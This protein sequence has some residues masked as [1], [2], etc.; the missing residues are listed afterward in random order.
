VTG[1]HLGLALAMLAGAAQCGT[2]G[3]PP[4]SHAFPV[5]EYTLPSGLK[6]V[7]EQDDVST[8]AGI[9]VVVDAGFVDDPAGKRGIAHVLEHLVFRVPDEKGESLWYRLITLGAASFNA[10]T[11]I[12]RTTYHAFGP[13]QTLDELAAMVLARLADPMR[14]AKE[15]HIQK[16][17]SITAEEMRKREGAAGNE[18]LM[19][20]LLPG[21]HPVGRAYAEIRRSDPVSLA[22]VRAFAD[23]FYRPERMTVVISGPVPDG[24]DK[25][26][27]AKL[28][29]ALRGQESARQPPVRRA[30]AA[31]EPP[32][33][34]DSALS[35][36]KGKVDVPELWMAWRVPPSLG[37]TAEKVYAVSWV[38]DMVLSSRLDP[39]GTNDVLDVDGFAYTGGL[40]SAVA[41]RFKLRDVGDAVRIRN[42]TTA[43]IEALSDAT[44]VSIKGRLYWSHVYALQAAKL[45]TAL[46]MDTIEG[47]ALARAELAHS[48]SSAL[49]SSV[50]SALEKVT[51]DDI[52]D[53][54]ARYLKPEAARSVLVV[55]QEAGP[56]RRRRSKP[57]DEGR[58]AGP[59]PEPEVPRE[60]QEAR[61]EEPPPPAPD[62]AKLLATTQAPNARAALV[63]KLSN[64]LTVIAMRRPGL[65]FVSTLLGFHSD[66]QPADAPGARY[67]YER[68]LHWELSAGPLELGLLRWKEYYADE[69]FES[70]RMFSA[71]LGKALDFLAEE[72]D[73]LHVYWPNPA[74]DRWLDESAVIEATP[75]GRA[76]RAFRTALFGK[77]PYH[78]TPT[79]AETRQLTERQVQAWFER[80]RRPANGAL[81][82]VGEIDPEGLV[83]DAERA[84]HGW[85]GDPSPPPAAPAPPAQPASALVPANV[86]LA[87]NGARTI[88]TEDPRRRTADVRFGC[89]LPPV[90]APRD[91][92]VNRLLSNMLSAHLSGQLRWKLAVN[93]SR[94]VGAETVR[95]GSSW[96]S[97]QF[98]V[99]ARAVAPALDLLHTWLDEGT[100]SPITPQRFD[101]LRWD[102]ARRS[103]LMNATGAQLAHSLFE[104][105]NMGWEPAVLDDYP[106]DLA[107]V[108][109]NDLNAALDTCRKSA[110]IS[111]LGPDGPP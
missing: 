51:T 17:L 3:T 95:G 62:M 109:V 16:E 93:Y 67:A 66:P 1:R 94:D 52:T 4:T 63:R 91:N 11:G 23:T 98:D 30:M 73:S 106:R 9:V 41:C 77:H 65:P 48:G 89:F 83:R 90:R 76:S 74:F 57:N 60:A 35:L 75:D 88:H 50:L 13:R 55:P 99:D 43:A 100:A 33:A 101:E 86:V 28:P 32:P 26:F 105:W 40:T 38:L 103:G 104:A 78:L 110:V 53:F 7:I 39:D 12:E 59:G 87:K 84:L 46:Q 29:P 44:L 34:G 10:F 5:Q 111:V 72:S 20:A 68:V 31:F 19:P 24:W 97:G 64:G 85:K 58:I 36:H 21:G 37:V 69:T 80:V 96:I 56:A 107:S 6:V 81:V 92:L 102:V 45:K 61:E 22:D 27:L 8:I 71:S 18:F 25:A 70:M 82:V 47:R 2:T 15:T 108:T 54:A 79:T 14:G 49:I 42:E